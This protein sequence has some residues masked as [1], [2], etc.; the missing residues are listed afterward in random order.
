MIQVKAE[1]LHEARRKH[2]GYCTRGVDSW[3]TKHGLSLREFLRNGYPIDVIEA[4]NDLLGKQVAQIARE[5]S[6]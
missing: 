1:H 5:R 3:F 4:T 6:K 2:G